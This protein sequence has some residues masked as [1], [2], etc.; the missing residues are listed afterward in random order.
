MFLVAVVHLYS[1]KQRSFLV[2]GWL[3]T[4]VMEFLVKVG[5]FS[6]DLHFLFAIVA[7]ADEDIEED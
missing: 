2:G 5:H 4:L 6:I 1:T 3:V 7:S